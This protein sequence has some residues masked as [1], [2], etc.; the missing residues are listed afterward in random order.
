[1]K[2]AVLLH[3]SLVLAVRKLSRGVDILFQFVLGSLSLSWE[4]G[5][6]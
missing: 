4:G 1:M 5:V 2:V 3:F 6:S